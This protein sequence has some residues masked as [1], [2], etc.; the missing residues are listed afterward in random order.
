MLLCKGTAFFHDARLVHDLQS[1][2]A[3]RTAVIRPVIRLQNRRDPARDP[4]SR[5]A[6]IRPVIRPPEP[7]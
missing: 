6:V 3:S 4:A 7:P 5:T 2:T 1:P